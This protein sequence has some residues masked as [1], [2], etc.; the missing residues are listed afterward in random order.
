MKS[1]GLTGTK[2][3]G[4]STVSEEFKKLGIPVFD[5]DLAIKFLLN[6][7]NSTRDKIIK[8]FGD[9]SYMGYNINTS[10]IS[11]TSDV[12]ELI[13]C[14]EFKIFDLYFNWR[15]KLHS[16]VNDYV[17]EYVIFM[18]SVIF[19][20]KLKHNFDKVISVF[21]PL[22]ER[23]ERISRNNYQDAFKLNNEYNP[24]LKNEKSDYVIHNYDDHNLT[25]QVK[26]I[27]NQI[28]GKKELVI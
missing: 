20:Q 24:I 9:N 13:Y 17:P 19:E 16:P 28:I 14:T 4:K 27:H 26:N 2:F 1:I 21:A 7:D 3:S 22:E 12:Y 6:Y 15:K 25:S 23:L 11:K 18:S 8:K 5:G 10:I